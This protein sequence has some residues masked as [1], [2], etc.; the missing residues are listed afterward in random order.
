[1]PNNEEHAWNTYQL[2]GLWARDLHAWMDEPCEKY[3]YWHRK[4]RHK[5][6]PPDWAIQKYG[7]GNAEK[8]MLDHIFLDE[9]PETTLRIE[10]P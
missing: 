8:I 7:L 3:G 4:Y 9:N 2:Y 1:M 5:P 10:I 6:H